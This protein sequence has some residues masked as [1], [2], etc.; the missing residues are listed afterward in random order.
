M[1]KGRMGSSCCNF[2]LSVLFLGSQ[3]TWV[4]FSGASSCLPMGLLALTMSCL[5]DGAITLWS[6]A[7]LVWTN[8]NTG[9][10]IDVSPFPFQQLASSQLIYT[11]WSSSLTTSKCISQDTFCCFPHFLLFTTVFLALSCHTRPME[12][13]WMMAQLWNLQLLS[14]V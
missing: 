14:W 9:I 7:Y 4:S 8:P 6:V 5:K 2:H 12:S 11:M 1:S 10:K 13:Q 3:P